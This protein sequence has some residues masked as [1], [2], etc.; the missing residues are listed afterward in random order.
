M[1]SILLNDDDDDGDSH[2]GHTD[3]VG[4]GDL[5]SV[6]S[7]HI[8]GQAQLDS[9]YEKAMHEHSTCTDATIPAG[10]RSHPRRRSPEAER[11][12]APPSEQRLT[13]TTPTSDAITKW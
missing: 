6:Q 9:D 10:S 13:R 12:R 2:D 1:T 11:Q 8:T 4:S 5:D 7:W 3:G